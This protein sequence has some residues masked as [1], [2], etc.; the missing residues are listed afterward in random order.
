MAV[1]KN[2][3]TSTSKRVLIGKPYR[4]SAL[5]VALLYAFVAALWILFSD[6]LISRLFPDPAAL[7]L[8][9]TLK[10]WGFVAVT[11]A[12]LYL[13][14]QRLLGKAAKANQRE[15]RLQQE[16]RRTDAFLESIANTSTDCIFVKDANS[17]YLFCNQALCDLLGMPRDQIIGATDFDL[18]PHAIAERFQSNDRRILKHGST[19][20]FE[21]PVE[22]EGQKLF[23]L[24][25]KGRLGLDGGNTGIFGIAR[26]IT[27]RKRIETALAASEARQR[28][29]IEHAPAALAMFD[30]QMRY[31]SVSK[32]WGTDFHVSPDEILGRSHYEVFPEIPERWKEVH[33]RSLAGEVV[34]ADEDSFAREDGR[35]QWV[36]WEVRPW[37][38]DEGEI[39]GIVIFTENITAYKQAKERLSNIEAE[40]T[41]ALDQFNDVVYLLDMK[42]RLLR[43]NQSFYRMINATPEECLGRPIQELIHPGGEATP[44]ALCCLQASP[45]NAVITL[46]PQ[47]PANPTGL[48]L[49][50]TFKLVQNDAG[51]EIAM[52]TSMHDL[53]HTREVDER[54]RLAASVFENALEGVVITDPDGTIVEVNRAFSDILGYSRDEV[55]GH[56]PRLWQSG[57]QNKDFYRGMWRAL[58]ETGHW[59]GE[60]WNRR[61]DGSVF[62]EWQTISSVHDQSGH[63]THY[64]GIFS[65]ISRIKQSQAQLDHLAHYDPLTDLPNRLLLQERLEQAIRHAERHQTQFAVIFLDIDHF[66]HINES[67]G[68]PVG[69][70]LLTEVAA[71]LRSQIRSDDTLSRVGGDEFVL[72]LET[73][74]TPA[75]IGTLAQELLRSFNQPFLLETHELNLTASLGISL[76]PQNGTDPVTLLRNADAAMYRSKDRGRNIYHFYTEELTQ[77]VVERVSLENHLRYAIE[78]DELFLVYQPQ[79]DLKSGRCVGVEA[80]LRWRHPELGLVSPAKF[81]PFAE[82]TGLIHNI[83][84]WVLTNACRQGKRWLQQGLDFG[85]L[86]VNIAGSQIERGNLVNDVTQALADSGL[87]PTRLELEVTEGF[88]MQ[89]PEVAIEQLNTLRQLGIILSIDDFGTGYSSLSYLKR[90]PIHKLKIDQS[91]VRDIPIDSDDMAICKAIIAM[92]ESLGLSVIAEGVE[93]QAQADFLLRQGCPQAQGYLYSKPLL[94][95][96]LAASL[97]ASGR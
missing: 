49:E 83:G 40:W 75:H 3:D 79:V 6:L 74:D 12:L 39:G 2:A 47:D 59:R 78:R 53:S 94:A 70:K 89:Q 41:Q 87:P 88:V 92:G 19:A 26:D 84:Q 77:N 57:Y 38:S 55:I 35:T 18:F 36:R 14:I 93:T 1:N 97:L 73:I 23:Y 32:R 48:P 85:T 65:D 17:R 27:E 28:L 91:F 46:E 13:M 67:L 7:T 82:E 51:D 56:N 96:D 8:A 30:T 34:R 24:V 68:H 4:R 90:L 43:A 80:L 37:Y 76:Y 22:A 95:D 5:S 50:V 29:F 61:K 15:M 62:P 60:L 44:C 33:R 66:K 9:S 42:H 58:L 54:L 64:V 31:L 86:A 72:L 81:I 52:L 21:E 25:T 71:R 10:G 20:V 69:D 63:L 11:S 16:K 45:R